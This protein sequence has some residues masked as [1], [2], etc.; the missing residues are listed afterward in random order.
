MIHLIEQG[1]PE[2][3]EFKES[4]GKNV[5]ET[6]C[7]FGNSRGIE[8]MM[9]ECTSAKMPDPVF[10]DKTNSFWITFNKGDD[11]QA[12]NE[13]PPKYP[14]SWENVIFTLEETRLLQYCAKPKDVKSM[15]AH[16]QLRDR[17]NFVHNYLNPF[18][19]K[20]ILRMTN[21]GSPRSPK[22]TY[23]VTEEWITV[24]NKGANPNEQI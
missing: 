22:Q 4:F 6:V 2:T 23:V 19:V 14:S 11:R 9:D 13:A 16:L 1:E 15:M 21:P 18:L 7:A 10:E 12:Q 5:I 8:K 20:G 17:K 24:H 3:L